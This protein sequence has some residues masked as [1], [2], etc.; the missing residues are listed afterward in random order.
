MS[1]KEDRI[2][3]RAYELWERAG[4]VHGAHE[5]H[6]LEATRQIELE[7]SDE[8]PA[9]PL[10]KARKSAVPNKAGLPGKSPAKAAP[11]PKAE[12]P[13]TAPKPSRAKPKKAM[14]PT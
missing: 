12:K 7:F 8:A 6:W 10:K 9:A 2:R 3:V 4:R 5:D 14:K 1:S 11:L 13:V